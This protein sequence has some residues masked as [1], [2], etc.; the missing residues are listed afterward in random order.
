MTS[1][2]KRRHSSQHSS[3]GTFKYTTMLQATC[4]TDIQ[5]ILRSK[6]KGYVAVTLNRFVVNALLEA[7]DK[8]RNISESSVDKLIASIE[9]T[10]YDPVGMMCMYE[11]GEL[12]D[13]QHRLRALQLLYGRGFH[14]PKT[15]VQMFNFG[16]SHE[17]GMDIDN[18]R[19]R[20]F[21]DSLRIDGVLKDKLFISALNQYAIKISGKG[22]RTFSSRE[23]KEIWMNDL[24]S[25]TELGNF[26]NIPSP[27]GAKKRPYSWFVVAFKFIQDEWGTAL[28][29][30]A[31]EQF[32]Y[33]DDTRNYMV[34]L[35]N[36]LLIEG[37]N[38]R[39]N[40]GTNKADELLGLVFYCFNHFM[41]RRPQK[42]PV[43]SS[44]S[45][46]LETNPNK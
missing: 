12:A 30:K 18:G 29:K 1:P 27:T 41:G 3:Y 14:L 19:I 40:A 2:K 35:R 22:R 45:E 46:P 21:A 25:I 17:R 24:C 34:A 6:H 28:A 15:P 43:L 37:P 7:N 38:L 9:A 42:A 13:G 31:L 33:G 8:N 4:P 32:Y 39:Y 26:E 16:L 20:S 11:D 23:L 5:D 10:G 44:K 36:Y